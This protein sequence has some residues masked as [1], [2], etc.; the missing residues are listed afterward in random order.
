MSRQY[1]EDIKLHQ[2]YRS[3]GYRLREKEIIKFAQRWDPQPFHTTPEFAKKTSF[4]GLIAAGI[5]LLAICAKLGT[6]KSDQP[7]WV[8]GLGIDNV[9]FV[10]PGRPGDVLVLE[11]EATSKR[12][13]D[14]IPNAGIVRFSFKLLNQREELVLTSETAILVEKRRKL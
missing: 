7:M 11:I 4:G 13:S 12:K 2:K 10:A 5:H 9:R 6:E 14:S 8:A 3:R 1:F